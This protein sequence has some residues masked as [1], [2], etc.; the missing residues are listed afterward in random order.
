MSHTNS[1]TNYSLPQFIT[2]DKPAWLTDINGAFSTIDTAIDAAKDAADDA[3]GDATQALT[4]AGTALT[5]A[6]GADSKASGCLASMANTFADTNTYAVGDLV[7]YNNLLYVCSTAV[8]VPGPW[9][10]STNW[11]R[12]NVDVLI[13]T[14]AGDLDT[15]ETEIS[16]VRILAN[17]KAKV[18]Q[19]TINTTT[20]AQ[21]LVDTG[22]LTSAGWLIGAY[23]ITNYGGYYC[24]TGLTAAGHF[25]CTVKNVSD[26]SIIANTA[27][28]IKIYYVDLT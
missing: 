25:Y 18:V 4:D 8:N 6:S 28:A 3:Q 9:T 23:P 7:T 10:G 1:T 5:T 2:T 13:S 22:L 14:V 19:D 21:G 12:K 24:V 16:N 27:V 20:T 26:N 15:A 11:T 17:S